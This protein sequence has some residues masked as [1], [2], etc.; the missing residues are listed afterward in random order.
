[1]EGTQYG[2]LLANVRHLPSD[3]SL[4]GEQ[5]QHNALENRLSGGV[6][7]RVGCNLGLPPANAK[8]QRAPQQLL[9]PQG[10]GERDSGPPP[11]LD[12]QPVDSLC[13]TGQ[14]AG[15][16]YRSGDQTRRV[17]AHSG[18]TGGKR[19]AE[20]AETGGQCEMVGSHPASL[21]AARMVVGPNCA[22]V[23]STANIRTLSLLAQPAHPPKIGWL[24]PRP[25]IPTAGFRLIGGIRT[26][27][28]R[29][30]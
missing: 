26:A 27:V 22:A 4:L 18:Q 21:R 16:A 17:V 10:C 11:A 25:E 14:G 24:Y 7:G 2:L 1:M 20:N 9:Q 30:G 3:G 12:I 28:F 5:S 19:Q 29:V 15:R 23:G 13:A 6:Q 8:T